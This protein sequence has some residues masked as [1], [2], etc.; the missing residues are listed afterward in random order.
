M[1]QTELA[2]KLGTTK[3][4]L[5]KWKAA[6]CPVDDFGKAQLWVRANTFLI[7]TK[8]GFLGLNI[9]EGPPIPSGRKGKTPARTRP[10]GA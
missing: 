5:S 6:G 10:A 9:S 1:T 8:S 4:N 3:G 7:M 2:K